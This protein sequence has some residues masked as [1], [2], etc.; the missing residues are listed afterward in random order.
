MEGSK[1]YL[2]RG[3]L[4]R[5]SMVVFV[6][7]MLTGKWAGRLDFYVSTSGD[8]EV[9]GVVPLHIIYVDVYI[10]QHLGNL[11]TPIQ[12][13]FH[14]ALVYARTCSSVYR[15]DFLCVFVCGYVCVCM[16]VCVS[17]PLGGLSRPQC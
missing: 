1:F 5:G 9:T 13:K 10:L 12:T 4:A 11:Q 7:Q 8:S 3:R 17:S 14:C 6:F 16:F 15:L 2:G